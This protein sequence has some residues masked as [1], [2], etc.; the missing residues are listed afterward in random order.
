M[1]EHRIEDIKDYTFTKVSI[2]LVGGME[3]DGTINILNH[4]RFSDYM[5]E[6]KSKYIRLHN[7]KSSGKQIQSA[8]KRFLLI[9]KDKI[10]FFE[11]FDM[12]KRLG[13]NPNIK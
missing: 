13:K 8:G 4:K 5:E 3:L 7:A 9:P 6:D 11:P 12:Q 2:I 10:L 1:K